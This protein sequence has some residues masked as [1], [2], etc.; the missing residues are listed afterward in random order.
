[1]LFYTRV[2]TGL[3]NH[4]VCVSDWGT[5]QEQKTT[6]AD[7]FVL[8][9]VILIHFT[10]ESVSKANRFIRVGRGI[11][12]PQAKYK[13]NLFVFVVFSA[14]CL[15]SYSH[16]WQP[17]YSEDVIP[18]PKQSRESFHLGFWSRW[19]NQYITNTPELSQCLFYSNVHKFIWKCILLLIWSLF[20]LIKT[21]CVAPT[22]PA[23]PPCHPVLSRRRCNILTV[24][25]YE[26]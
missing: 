11:I 3:S 12:K 20:A 13:W 26:R 5:G 2:L 24:L 22:P 18:N 9:V 23:V 8:V 25:Y 15:V 16:P 1:M 4:F 10:A 14:V 21:S 19:P 7:A 17:K 6:W